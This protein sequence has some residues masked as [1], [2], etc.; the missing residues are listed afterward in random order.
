MSVT[1]VTGFPDYSSAG[2]SKFIPE[3]WS[4][5]FL[6]KLNAKE[7][8]AAIS[9]TN[10]KGE[11]TDKGDKV[12]VRTVPDVT[13]RDY[14]KGQDLT[15]ENLESADVELLID[16]AKYFAFV[17]DDIDAYQSDLPLL[18][19]WA[20]QAS[21]A[22]GNNV[23]THVLASIKG[24]VHAS[25]K[26][27]TAGVISGDINLGAAGAPFQ[28]TK[29]IVLEFIVDCGVVLGEQNVEKE[30]S[31]AVVPEWFGGIIQKSD[32][33]D[34]SMT[35][36]GKSVLRN[37]RI[38]IIWPF[39]VFLSN[40]LPTTS[41]GVTCW[42][43]PFGNKDGLTFAQQIVKTKNFDLGAKGFGEGIKGLNVFGHK[44]MVS[45]MLG[46]GYVRK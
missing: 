42:D 43:I 8:L 28:V 18:K 7:V 34:A 29:D 14:N 25:N 44:V 27:A 32:L 37:G 24:E 10:Y 19:R 5:N 22:M 41:D 31:W 33:K 3:I 30:G 40:N 11:I 36:D 17:I 35:G 9:N 20:T 46:C 1:R 26:G 21:T 23:D 4:G 39:E 15:I 13:I 38:G 45:Q 2:T 16:H 12:I 6:V